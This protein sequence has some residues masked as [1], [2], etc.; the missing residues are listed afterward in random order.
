MRVLGGRG[1][2]VPTGTELSA[3]RSGSGGRSRGKSRRLSRRFSSSRQCEDPPSW[4]GSAGHVCRAAEALTTSP[5]RQP[6]ERGRLVQAEALGGGGGARGAALLAQ[7]GAADAGF[8]AR[9]PS[10]LFFGASSHSRG[11][12]ASHPAGSR[13]CG[14]LPETLNPVTASREHCF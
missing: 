1:T 9:S 6:R 4:R 12:A 8:G 5:K 13:G 10:L 3:A 7:V 11:H 14:S 2:A